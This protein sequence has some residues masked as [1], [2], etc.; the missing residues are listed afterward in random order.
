MIA[1]LKNNVLSICANKH[2]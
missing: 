2:C 1:Y